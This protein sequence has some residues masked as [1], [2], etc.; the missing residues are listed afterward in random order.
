[1]KKIKKSNWQKDINGDIIHI[2]HAEKTVGNPPFF[3]AF[4]ENFKKIK[5]NFT[6]AVDKGEM[7]W[8]SNIAV[9]ESGAL[10]N[11]WKSWKKKFSRKWKKVLD[12]PEKM[13]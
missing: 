9:G 13:W 2:A 12:K 1:M 3:S 7:L 10:K 5:K 6:K 4:Q 8:Y 11:F